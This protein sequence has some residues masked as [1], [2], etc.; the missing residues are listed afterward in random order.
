MSLTVAPE[1]Q[2]GGA[3]ARMKHLRPENTWA[4]SVDVQTPHFENSWIR[5]LR[6]FGKVGQMRI[7]VVLLAK[8]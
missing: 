3:A 5:A 4:L 1:W 2:R 8:R 6:S 7:C